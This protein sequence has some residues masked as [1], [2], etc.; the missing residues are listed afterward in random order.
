MRLI[1]V[2]QGCE[3]E[4]KNQIENALVPNIWWALKPQC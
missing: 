2:L 4:M 1:P 3:N